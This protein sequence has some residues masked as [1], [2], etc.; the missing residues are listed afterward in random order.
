MIDEL[1]HIF[2]VRRYHHSMLGFDTTARTP[3][4]DMKPGT[5]VVVAMACA[6][7]FM[8]VMDASIIA[9]AT[10]SIGSDLQMSPGALSWVVNAYVL[11]FAGGMLVGGRLGDLF[12]LRR[13]FILA[14]IVFAGASLVAGLASEGWQLL[15]ARAVQG[16][17]GAALAP[18]SLALISATLPEGPA[19]SRAVGLWTAVGIAGGAVGNVV[20]GTLT[21]LADWRWVFWLNVP[22]GVLAVVAAAIVLQ[23]PTSAQRKDPAGTRAR[24]LDLQGAAL[25]TVGLVIASWAISGTDLIS[26]GALS[27]GWPRFGALAIGSLLLIAFVWSQRRPTTTPVQEGTGTMPVDPLLPLGLFA[28]RGISSGTVTM[29]LA[30]ATLMPMWFYISLLMQNTLGYNP[31]RAG[32]GFLP[33][34]TV[35]ALIGAGLAPRLMDRVSA[36]VLVLCGCLIAA[37]G[38]AWQAFTAGPPTSGDAGTYLSVILGPAIV[39]SVGGGLLNTPLTT[40]ILA[41]ASPNDSGAVSGLLNTTKQVG[42]AIG[43]AALTALLATTGPAD[44][45][46]AF[47]AMA[48]LMTLAT[49]SSMLLPATKTE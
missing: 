12:G 7:E 16:M 9:I 21:Q 19:R 36:R 47:I 2:M 11:M 38:F 14:T 25:A 27:S 1:W 35:T 48:A 22:L 39:I 18:V 30:G 24:R 33:H 13:V 4:A 34:A 15:A 26:S 3:R 28:H 23:A 6:A 37:A 46:P 43:L 44:Y 20:G 29:L 17:G 8:V 10:P 41:G 31:L 45:R 5:S 32:L 49:A 40:A 42:A